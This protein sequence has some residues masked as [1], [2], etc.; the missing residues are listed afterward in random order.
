MKEADSR[1]QVKLKHCPR[2]PER[3][4]GCSH[5][6]AFEAHLAAIT[7][8]VPL[9]QPLGSSSS[10]TSWTVFGFGSLSAIMLAILL[11]PWT[12]TTTP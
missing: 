2:G 5:V 3:A 11:P 12:I 8:F 7:I 9:M 4:L 1:V 10:G 6:D